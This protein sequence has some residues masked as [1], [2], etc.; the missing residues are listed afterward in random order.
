MSTDLLSVLRK[1]I[2]SSNADRL[3]ARLGDALRFSE[4]Y[5]ESGDGTILRLPQWVNNRLDLESGALGSDWYVDR[6][7]TLSTFVNSDGYVQGAGADVLVYENSRVVQNIVPVDKATSLENWSA[8]NGALVAGNQVTFVNTNS[9]VV[10]LQSGMP[11][12]HY[13]SRMIVYGDETDIDIELVDNADGDPNSIQSISV[14]STPKIISVS[15]DATSGFSGALRF[16]FNRSGTAVTAGTTITVEDFQTE[17]TTAKDD[18]TIPGEYEV[19][20]GSND[21]YGIYNTANGNSVTDGV[22]TEAVGAALDPVP[23]MRHAPGATNNIYPSTPN[24]SDWTKRG[25][26]TITNVE[27]GHALGPVCQVRGLGAFVVDDFYKQ[28]SAFAASI[29]IE[30][31]LWVKAVDTSGTITIR[32]T[33]TGE[34]W[35]IDLSLVSTTIFEKMTRDHAAVSVVDDWNSN[36][37]GAAGMVI[38]QTGGG[39]LD[40]DMLG[41]QLEAGTVSTPSIPTTTGTASRTI[42]SILHAYSAAVFD[43]DEGSCAIKFTLDVDTDDLAN[44]FYWLKTGAGDYPLFNSASGSQLDSDDNTTVITNT[45]TN[46]TA[47]TDIIL[48]LNWS[49]S[50]GKYENAVGS[51]WS[52]LTNFDGFAA[53]LIELMSGTT[54]VAH[55]E[56]F[57]VVDTRL[58]QSA[59][60]A[61]WT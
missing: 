33:T 39:T 36:G 50:E 20:D 52:T 46:I 60:E 2:G 8:V 4:R 23:Y 17:N 35:T 11:S 56:Y 48:R 14:T 40:F 53:A 44:T 41:V 12:G 37:S 51:D 19:V 6:S 9:D 21:G 16:N 5:S 25:S 13:T 49:K 3:P 47:G 32:N 58:S 10:L 26:V 7:G 22:V 1:G 45:H 30:P 54:V 15:L 29:R 38:Y 61:R 59:N 18:P 42:D 34:V 27:E 55:I 24:D 57:D 31:S 43:V 28:S